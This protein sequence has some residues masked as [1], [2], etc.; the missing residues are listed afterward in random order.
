M[1]HLLAL[2]PYK[3]E[4]TDLVI[5]SF[6]AYSW[7]FSLKATPKITNCLT[8]GVFFRPSLYT[9]AILTLLVHTIFQNNKSCKLLTNKHFKT[10][11]YFYSYLI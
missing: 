7:I 9:K 11:S 1:L 5:I 3:R 6:Q 10:I 8:I 4:E 2:H